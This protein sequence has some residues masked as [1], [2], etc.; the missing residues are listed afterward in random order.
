MEQDTLTRKKTY[1]RIENKTSA[2]Q[3]KN[4]IIK[5]ALENPVQSLRK[6]NDASLYNFLRCFWNEVSQKPFQGN[7]HI[8]YLCSQLEQIAYQVS[9]RL[10]K[11]HD[12][13]INEPPGMTKT[14]VCSIAF[15]VWCWTK[16]PWMRFITA[17]YS[18]ALSLEAAE[19]S[20]DLIRSDKFKLIYPDVEIKEDKDQKSN[21]KVVT[22]EFVK[23]GQAP[24]IK[25][26]GN[27]FSTSVGGTLAGFH[28]D[29]LIIDD[30]LNPYE[31]VSE[32]ELANA[33]RW[34][35]E[36]LPTR[37]TDKEASTKIIVMQRLHQDDPSGH[38]LD[39]K[40]ENLKHIS[41]PGEIRT[42]RDQLQPA[43]EL[44]KGIALKDYYV[45]DLLDPVRLSWKALKDLETDL[46]QYGFSGQIGQNP[47]PP[48]GGMFHVDHF[49]I[50][51]SL[52][53]GIRP[54]Q[55]IRY[56]DKAGSQGKGCFTAG[57]KMAKLSNGQFLVLDVKRGQWSTDLRE[58][59]IRETAEADGYN[60]FVWVEQEP[61]SSGK[62][63]SEGT[64]RNLA[65]FAIY[66]ERPTGD[67]ETR[68][69]PYSVQVNNG[70]VFLQRGGWNADFIKEYRFFPYG[71]YKD[72]I[73][74]G[75]GAF[76]HLA[77]KRIARRIT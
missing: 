70:N 25:V 63:S 67:K 49:Q 36:T 39:K 30:P 52:P 24:R 59:I 17:S 69:V 45:D 75:S 54:I 18:A 51:D 72:Q 77:A 7:W 58:R 2:F 50:V 32:K 26:G 68:A 74:A 46:G 16:W 47:V 28:G 22:K 21:Y 55:V 35:D 71:K 27:R 11:E 56:W 66:A 23:A 44:Y 42:F 6:L 20:R 60:V 62:E 5:M 29:I 33:N 38:L 14:L 65:G 43:D 53:L 12:L 9:K 57:V 3:D 10:P 13:I 8:P 1:R 31:A 48:G 19:Y 37:T 76:N 61:G 4:A 40:K 41:L 64:I 73:D 34:I 15:P